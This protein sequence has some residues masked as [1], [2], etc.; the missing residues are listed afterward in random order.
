MIY[1]LDKRLILE[2]S[3]SSTMLMNE[4]VTEATIKQNDRLGPNHPTTLKNLAGMEK[5]AQ[6]S[7]DKPLEEGVLIPGMAA[8]GAAGLAYTGNKV[9]DKGVAIIQRHNYDTDS[10]YESIAGTKG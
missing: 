3:A 9:L 2:A 6:K 8:A 1:K 5:N 10:M 7:A 4:K